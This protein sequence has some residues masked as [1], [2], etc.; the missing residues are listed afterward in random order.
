MIVDAEEIE[1]QR[2]IYLVPFPMQR[3]C[4][5]IPSFVLWARRKWTGEC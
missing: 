5:I 1:S 2:I 4:E 3:S